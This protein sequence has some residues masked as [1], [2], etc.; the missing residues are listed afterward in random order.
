MT[1]HLQRLRVAAAVNPF[2]QKEDTMKIVNSR[3]TIAMAGLIAVFL[4]AGSADKVQANPSP[5]AG[6]SGFCTAN[7]DFGTSHGQCV[8]VGETNVN[9]LEQRGVTDAVTGCAR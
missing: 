9:A 4:L 1:R 7:N 8:S 3:L 2:R 5:N 6:V